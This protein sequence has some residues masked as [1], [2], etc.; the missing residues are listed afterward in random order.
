M[1]AIG[2]GPR[3][4]RVAAFLFADAV[5]GV[6]LGDDGSGV[7]LAACFVCG[8]PIPPAVGGDGR[9][10]WAVVGRGAAHYCCYDP[11]REPA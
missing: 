1:T 4:S 10:S 8:Q 3:R 6:T 2:D 9:T 7:S 5:G 11:R